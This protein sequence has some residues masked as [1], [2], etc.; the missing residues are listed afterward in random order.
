VID[1][2]SIS[3][4]K[5]RMRQFYHHPKPPASGMLLDSTS[6]KNMSISY[7]PH[8]CL[9]SLC[10]VGSI[11]CHTAT[12]RCFSSGLKNNSM[13]SNRGIDGRS[14]MSLERLMVVDAVK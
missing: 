7:R 13:V 8:A 10:S 5:V 9:P 4:P 12:T 11:A 1:A 6:S 3:L 2:L 14:H